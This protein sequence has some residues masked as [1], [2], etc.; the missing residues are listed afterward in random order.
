MQHFQE[1]PA[2]ATAWLVLLQQI[3]NNDNNDNKSR[4]WLHAVTGLQ[5]A[6]TVEFLSENTI[7]DEDTLIARLFICDLQQS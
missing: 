3:M 1:L 7:L 2:E 4:S 5:D 6:E